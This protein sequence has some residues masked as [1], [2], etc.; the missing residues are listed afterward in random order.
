MDA[1]SLLFA[2]A[3]ANFLLGLT[4]LVLT[5][6]SGNMLNEALALSERQPAPARVFAPVP[7]SSEVEYPDPVNH[8]HSWTYEI[9]DGAGWR[10]GILIRPGYRCGVA[11][12]EFERAS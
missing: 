3:G 9:N 11:K 4:N 7:T 1:D 6:R 2:L 5:Y 8:E 10:C 12:K